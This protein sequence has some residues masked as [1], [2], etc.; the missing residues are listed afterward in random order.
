MFLAP[1]AGTKG[2]AVIRLRRHLRLSPRQVF[3]IGDGP[4]DLTML[5]GRA[6]GI[7]ACVA[8]ALLQ[9]KDT[10]TGSGGYVAVSDDAAGVVEALAAIFAD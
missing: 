10:V 8:N 3:A 9:V 5:D 4:N 1:A 2:E 6:A 7:T